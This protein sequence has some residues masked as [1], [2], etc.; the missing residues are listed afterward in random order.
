MFWEVRTLALTLTFA[1]LRASAPELQGL[2]AALTRLRLSDLKVGPPKD[3]QI[4]YFAKQIESRKYV[5]AGA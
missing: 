3:T 1:N 2:K 4:F 5:S